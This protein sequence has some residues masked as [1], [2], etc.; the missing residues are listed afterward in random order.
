M[1]KVYIIDIKNLKESFPYEELYNKASSYRKKKVD[2]LRFEKDKFLSLSVDYLLRY[3]L[4]EIGID[5]SNIK[6]DFENNN[7]PILKNYDGVFFN[8]SHSEDI[9]MCTI[10]NDEVGC[11]VQKM[12]NNSLEIADRFFCNNELDLIN[13]QDTFE[14]K[15]EMFYR[16]WT[17]KESYMKALGLG[18]ELGLSEFEIYFE[19]G[20]AKVLSNKD[21]DTN[22]YF[23]EIKLENRSFK[24]SIC[25]KCFE[26]CEVKELDKFIL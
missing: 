22:F 3:A 21:L 4:S 14:E 2:K 8:L 13:R 24:C 12:A 17:L 20:T 18:F 9:A 23:E 11:D 15:R 5:Y 19:N 26:K 10:S 1:N 6:I 25:S 16:I 7:K